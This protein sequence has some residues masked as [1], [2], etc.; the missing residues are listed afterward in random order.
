MAK[1]GKKPSNLR[2]FKPKQR[3]VKTGLVEL[4]IDALAEDGRGVARMNGKAVFVEGALPT[5]TVKAKYTSVRKQFDEAVCVKALAV[6]EY[7]VK[8]PCGYAG[9]CGGCALQHLSH[10]QQLVEKYQQLQQL[11]NPHQSQQLQA[12]LWHEVMSAEPSH[13]RHRV[14]FAIN[15]TKEQVIIGFKKHNAHDVIAIEQCYIADQKINETLPLLNKVV[16]DLKSRSRLVECSVI[17][18]ETQKMAWLMVCKQPLLETDYQQLKA[19]AEQHKIAI[20]VNNSEGGCLFSVGETVLTYTLPEQL[21]NFNY[22]VADFTQVNKPINH[23]MIAKA[24]EWLAL[25]S[26]ELVIDFFCGIGNITLPLAQQ[27]KAVIGYEAVQQM[28]DK[29]AQNAHANG[30]TNCVFEQKDLFSEQILLPTTVTTVVLDPPRAGAKM[31]SQALSTSKV[32]KILYISCNPATLARDVAILQ[33]GGFV[34]KQAQLIDMFPHTRH[35][36]TMMLLER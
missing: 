10:P 20:V 22:A 28:L 15:A 4:T 5:E 27:A 31:L 30:L 13:Y 36:E 32:K 29:A 24:L 34:I 35:V 19:C 6:S 14:R 3:E 23:L 21:L 11:F 7:R 17:C 25:Q 16:C 9:V 18:D 26:D 1:M 12:I 2:L 8:P 33:A